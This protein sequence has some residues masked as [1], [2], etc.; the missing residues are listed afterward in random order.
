M[1]ESTRDSVKKNTYKAKAKQ[2]KD[3][4][5]ANEKKR[6][7]SVFQ[8]GDKFLKYNSARAG[9]K[10]KGDLNTSY[11]GPYL[12][13]ELVGSRVRLSSLSGNP[14]KALVSNNNIKIFNEQGV[15]EEQGAE[16]SYI[17]QLIKEDMLQPLIK[18]IQRYELPRPLS[19]AHSSQLMKTCPVYSFVNEV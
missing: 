1:F 2:Q 14:L 12:I 9:K 6:G 8:V 5:N 11:T 10:S 18:E 7:Y 4:K 13:S 17:S 15:S 3:F 16:E 19:D